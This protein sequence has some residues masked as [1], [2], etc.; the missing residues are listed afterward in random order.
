MTQTSENKITLKLKN[1]YADLTFVLSQDANI[2]EWVDVF[3]AALK[4]MGYT[5]E[6]MVAE[7]ENK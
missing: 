2:D 4:V 5:S 3:N 6:L 7:K 1:S